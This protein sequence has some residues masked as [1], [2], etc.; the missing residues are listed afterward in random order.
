MDTQLELKNLRDKAGDFRN[1]KGKM[2]SCVSLH[3]S[4]SE[5]LQIL[6]HC[7]ICPTTCHVY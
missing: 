2:D 1:P 3:H 4:G 7:P 5:H 6:Q